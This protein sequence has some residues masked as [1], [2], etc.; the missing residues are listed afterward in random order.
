MRCTVGSQGLEERKDVTMPVEQVAPEL[1][2]I[3]SLD[4]EVE[5]LGSG[6]GGDLVAEGPLWW[7]EGGYLLFSDMGN[8][9]RLKWSRGGG[10][11]GIF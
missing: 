11:N 7:A 9:R 1:E 3:V 2:R 6:Y 4:Q 5:E 10:R 8:S